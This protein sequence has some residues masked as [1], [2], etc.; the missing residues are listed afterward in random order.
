MCESLPLSSLVPSYA[1]SLE[2]RGRTQRT[3]ERAVNYSNR[4]RRWLADT[5]YSEDVGDITSRCLERY[6]IFLQ[7]EVSA[8][9]AGIHFRTLRAPFG[10]LLDEGEIDSN[11]FIASI[12]E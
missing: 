11:P 2:V 8:I 4:L 1:T 10:W 3:V 6:F 9:S 5:D 12:P 7:T